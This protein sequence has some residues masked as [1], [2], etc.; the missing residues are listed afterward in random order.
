MR[1]TANIAVATAIN[2]P[3]FSENM[4]SMLLKYEDL[5]TYQNNDGVNLVR[6]GV[7]KQLMI[8][9]FG[10]LELIIQTKRVFKCNDA[11]AVQATLYICTTEG[12]QPVFSRLG[13]ASASDLPSSSAHS[14]IVGY[15][16][17]NAEKRVLQALGL[18]DVKSSEMSTLRGRFKVNKE[19]INAF[20]EKESVSMEELVM[21][22]NSSSNTQI[23]T[24]NVE[25]LSTTE[26]SV[27]VAFI[28]DAG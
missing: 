16:E 8:D 18:P 5:P 24:F 10:L 21:S 22:F 27:L 14:N 9:S 6:L 20:L 26:A 11:A 25:R 28:N 23:K 3:D 13:Y 15:A 12:Y 4:K 19:D 17:S 1:P 7:R 2:N